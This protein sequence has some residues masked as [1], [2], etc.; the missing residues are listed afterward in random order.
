M[1]KAKK[2]LRFLVSARVATPQ[3]HPR[4]GIFFFGYEMMGGGGRGGGGV[5]FF[6][7]NV[8]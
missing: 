5:R 4:V 2:S 3:T 7:V 1:F 8:V 6:Y